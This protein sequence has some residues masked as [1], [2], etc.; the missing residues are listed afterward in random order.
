MQQCIIVAVAEKC[1]QQTNGTTVKLTS[2]TT[3]LRYIAAA[4]RHLYVDQPRQP[5][6]RI[7]HS[8]P[9]AL[10]EPAHDHQLVRRLL[11]LFFGIR[12]KHAS[13]PFNSE[14]ARQAPSQLSFCSKQTSYFQT[15]TIYRFHY[16]LLLPLQHIIQG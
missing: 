12:L 5:F 16:K 11:D 1:V 10:G 8:V 9:C 3:K 4:E 2:S 6:P 14:Q 13:K 15:R 7:L